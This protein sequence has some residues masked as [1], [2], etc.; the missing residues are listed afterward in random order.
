MI[1]KQ[2]MEL[3]AGMNNLYKEVSVLYARYTLESVKYEF[4]FHYINNTSTNICKM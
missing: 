4:L 1:D 2:K 3:Q